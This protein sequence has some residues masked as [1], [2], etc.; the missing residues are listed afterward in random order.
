VARTAGRLGF[1]HDDPIIGR[2]IEHVEED[3]TEEFGPFVWLSGDRT[4]HASPL[5]EGIVLT[6]VLNESEKAMGALTV[7]FDLAGFGGVAEP[8]I[9]GAPVEPVSAEP[10]HLAWWGPDGWLDRFEVG[11]V[12]AVRVG[13]EGAID[14]RALPEAPAVDPELVAAVR[15][16]YEQEVAEPQVPVSGEDLVFG[17]LAT[18]RALF[19][20]IQAPLDMLCGAASLNRQA[21]SVAHD[22]EIWSTERMLRRVGRVTTEAGGDEDLAERVLGVLDLADRLHT[23]GDVD[24]AWTLRALDDLEDLE[25]LD[26][27][28]DEIF[29]THNPSADADA[30]A[31]HLLELARR[32]SHVATAHLIAAHAAETAGDWAAAEQHLELAVRADPDNVPA[33]D[34]LAWYIGD[35]GNAA[36]ATRLW[37]TCPRSATIGQDLETI[38]P[39][40]SRHGPATSTGH[41]SCGPGRTNRSWSARSSRP[42]TTPPVSPTTSTPPTTATHPDSGGPS[43]TTSTTSP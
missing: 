7:S 30:L 32:P 31:T 2:L 11:T 29:D 36:R 19:D 40:S 15:Q 35:R 34:R 12:L 13:P 33:V 6:H 4:A 3:L 8:S 1:D 28:T 23:G 9:D 37:R 18:D 22:P 25:V 17:L 27:V 41:R 10:G 16:V 42:P 26:L 38:V 20:N 39:T 21:S 24:V 14:L 5:R 43:T